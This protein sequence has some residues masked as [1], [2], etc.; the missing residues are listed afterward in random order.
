MNLPE[1][2]RLSNELRLYLVESNGEITDQMIEG[3]AI[4]E[5]GLPA[6]VDS[7]KFVIDDMQSEVDKWKAKAEE[8][9]KVSK[10]YELF[11]KRLKEN[12]R[13][14]C[15]S[16][17]KIELIG[18]TYRWKLQTSNPALI[19]ED[20]RLIPQKYKTI[21]QATEIDKKQLIA[22]LKAL[23]KDETIPGCKLETSNHV[24]SYPNNKK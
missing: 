12:I 24:R 18:N 21:I 19:I 17:D 6:K 7:Y 13:I 8:F 5:Q 1:L 9:L 15:I 22:D 2:V 20:E 3:L 14:A 4:V 16:M 10:G 23:K 11:I